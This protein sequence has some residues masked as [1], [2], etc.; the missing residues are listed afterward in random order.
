MK[1]LKRLLTIA[2]VVSGIGLGSSCR[3]VEMIPTSPTEKGAF[4]LFIQDAMGANYDEVNLD[5]QTVEV[6]V[7][8]ETP[9]WHFIKTSSGV[10]NLLKLHSTGVLLSEESG[11]PAGKITF[12]RLM[13][14]QKNSVKFKGQYYPLKVD[15]PRGLLVIMPSGYTI[16]N[17]AKTDVRIDFNSALSVSL[18]GEETA[19]PSYI[20]RPAITVV[21]RNSPTPGFEDVSTQ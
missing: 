14:G 11:I 9:G 4:E 2:V 8:N 16:H 18:S 21:K 20:F 15:A 10:Y 7:D 1:A 17:H 19:G 6:Y 13:A 12:M 5:I 3:K